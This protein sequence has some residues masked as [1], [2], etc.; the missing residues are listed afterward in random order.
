MSTEQLI[1]PCVLAVAQF[2]NSSAQK[3]PVSYG[4]SQTDNSVLEYDIDMCVDSSAL[5]C[6]AVGVAQLHRQEHSVS[7]VKI[8]AMQT[9]TT[10]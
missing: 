5:A 7:V 10:C 9:Y 1:H 2:N 3:F 6:R 4:C 8:S